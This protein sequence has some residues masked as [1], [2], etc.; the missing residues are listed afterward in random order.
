M[1]DYPHFFI[2]KIRSFFNSFHL[3]Y[4]SRLTTG[5]H[6]A[7][8]AW[9]SCGSPGA[10]PN[11]GSLWAVFRLLPLCNSALSPPPQQCQCKIYFQPMWQPGF[12]SLKSPV[13][14]FHPSSSLG[15]SWTDLQCSLS[16]ASQQVVTLAIKLHLWRAQGIF[17]I[18]NWH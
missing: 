18:H 6:F 12:W 9:T 7:S 14:C 5:L 3:H 16:F 15:S 17:Q 2:V 1:A 10:Y 8:S 13:V 4:N 11:R